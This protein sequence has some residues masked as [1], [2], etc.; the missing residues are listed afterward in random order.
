MPIVGVLV[1]GTPDPSVAIK[2]FREGLRDLGYV[3]GR[4]IRIEVRSAEGNPARLPELA[5][6]LVRQRVDVIAAW[7]TPVVPAAKRATRTIPIVMMAAGDPVGLGLVASLARPG[8][9]VTGMAGQTSEIAA[10]H[11]EFLKEVMPSLE[12]I[13]ALCN[14]AD[15]FSARFLKY[16]E[17]AGKDQEIAITPV[18][19]TSTVPLTPAVTEIA[20]EKIPALIVQPSL[21][22][23]RAAH[24]ALQHRLAAASPFERFAQMGGLM[25][26]SIKPSDYYRRGAIFVAK[27]LKGAKPADLPVEQP[28]RFQL[29]INLKTA[30]AIG[31]TLPNSLLAQADEVIE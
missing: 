13:A 21:P 15:P 7:F 29:V 12:R 30:R 17:T 4:N 20:D 5:E 3:D 1:A 28:T 2:F 22:L 14:A 9:N 27:I 23:K 6:A 19:V 31:V 25:A 24:L 10:K 26:Y 16:I 8:G 18:S 11:V